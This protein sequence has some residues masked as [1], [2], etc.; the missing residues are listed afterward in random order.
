MGLISLKI[1]VS[2]VASRVNNT[3]GFPLVVEVRDLLTKDEIVLQLRA[4]RT[5][6]ERVL[7]VGDW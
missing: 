6:T 5:D 7:I 4:A 2:R 3:L 1:S